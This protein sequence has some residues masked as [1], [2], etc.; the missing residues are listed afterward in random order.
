M[1]HYHDPK[2][3]AFIDQKG[4]EMGLISHRPNLQYHFKILDTPVINAFAVPGGYIYFTRGILAQLNNE[5]E[6]MGIMAHEMGHVVYR[7]TASQQAKQTIGQIALIGAM[8]ASKQIAQYAEQAMQG[9]QLLF[10]KFSRDNE[11]EADRIGVEY[12]TKMGYDAHKMADFFAVLQK[13]NLA[14]EHGGVPTFMSTHP[15]PGDRYNTVHQLAAQAQAQSG[16]TSQ[17]LVNADPYLKMIEGMVYGEDPRQGFVENSVFYHPELKFRYNVPIG[18]KYENT[19][20]QVNMVPQ[21]GKALMIFTMAQ[22]KTAREA[23]SVTIQQLKLQMLENKETNING[24]PA[25]L[26]VCQQTQQDQQTGQS[27]TIKIMSGYIEYGGVVYVF[28]GVSSDTDFNNYFQQFNTSIG[29]FNRLTDPARLNVVPKR[30]R[31]QSVKSNGTFTSALKAFNVPD[32]MMK[33]IAFLNNI[34]LTDQ[35]TRGKLI[36]IIGN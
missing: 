2:V 17:W 6:L 22:Q 33:E 25:I 27:A 8:V 7:H 3:Q 34:E 10:F 19:P 15:D 24:L 16:N 29:S 18:W 11:R 9:L 5:A 20:V 21:D 31:V 36:K 1:G 12:S 28:H 14:S 4:K 26:T 23:A 13:M 30:L 35:V 32:A